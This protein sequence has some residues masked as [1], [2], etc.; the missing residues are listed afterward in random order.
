MRG[1]RHSKQESRKDTFYYLLN[2]KDPVTGKMF[3]T[4]ELQADSALIIAAGA[5]IH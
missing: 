4:E 5:N 2:S 1:S 3:T